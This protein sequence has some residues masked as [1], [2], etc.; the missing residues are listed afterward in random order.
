MID[1][2]AVNS[3]APYADTRIAYHEQRAQYHINQAE[4]LRAKHDA[5]DRPQIPAGFHVLEALDL[6]VKVFN[7]LKRNGIKT[8]EEL[9]LLMEHDPSS[10]RSIKHMGDK[11]MN[12]ISKRLNAFYE[13]A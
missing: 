13:N 3:A 2:P 12:E 8:V 5:V 7:T 4:R 10:I 1:K 11:S 6:P 9:Q